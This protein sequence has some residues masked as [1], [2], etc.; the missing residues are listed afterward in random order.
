MTDEDLMLEYTAVVLDI[1]NLCERQKID[2]KYDKSKHLWY[3]YRQSFYGFADKLDNKAIRYA[4]E[5]AIQR[6]G[7]VRPG[8]SLRD[9]DYIKQPTFEPTG[10]RQN[11]E[12]HLEH[13]W[14]GDM[15]RK[16]LNRLAETNAL[17]VSRVAE[18]IRANYCQAWIMKSEN[19][20][21]SR[22][23]RG[24]TLEDA[25]GVYSGSGIQLVEL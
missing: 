22:S 12:F 7:Q 4:S 3:L 5:A 24:D 8:E 18:L 23:D 6:F 17:S 10:S 20:K 19:A 11:G 25:L 13:I 9:M 1:L 21:L 16:A 2:G 14:T 15:F